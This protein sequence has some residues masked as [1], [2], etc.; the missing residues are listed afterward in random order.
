MLDE[1]GTKSTVDCPP[2]T[3]HAVLTL[4][5]D[6]ALARTS[7]SFTVGELEAMLEALRNQEPVDVTADDFR[8][9]LALAM[10]A[11]PIE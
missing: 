1:A 8:H 6:A 2:E 3:F 11:A 10:S 5:K 7:P 4:A 9:L